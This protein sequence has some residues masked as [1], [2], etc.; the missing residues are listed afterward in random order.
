MT[1]LSNA[2]ITNTTVTDIILDGNSIVNEGST[3]HGFCIMKILV[4]WNN[5]L[6]FIHIVNL[7]DIF[8]TLLILIS[9]PN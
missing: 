7:R 4:E 2:L 6:I 9:F 8:Y 5:A 3:A 1:A